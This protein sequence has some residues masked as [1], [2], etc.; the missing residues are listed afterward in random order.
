MN[1]PLTS[2]RAIPQRNKSP[3]DKNL[4]T[5][6]FR[7]PSPSDSEDDLEDYH[8]PSPRNA[9]ET[10]LQILSSG[11]APRAENEDVV[12]VSQSQVPKAKNMIRKDHVDV[13]GLDTPEPAA[14]Q[15]KA[16]DTVS[17]PANMVTAAT[18]GHDSEEPEVE[19]IIKQPL[20]S[21]RSIVIDDEEYEQRGSKDRENDM[22]KSSV[23]DNIDLIEELLTYQP[24]ER[25]ASK[26]KEPDTIRDRNQGPFAIP[27]P[28]PDMSVE[29]E[30]SP[31]SD[32]HEDIAQ[33][34]IDE[35]TDDEIDYNS[36]SLS[37]HSNSLFDEQKNEL[38]EDDI[39]DRNG[40]ISF[41]L[42]PK[43]EEPRKRR[44][45]ISLYGYDSSDDSDFPPSADKD[46]DADSLIE[47][48]EYSSVRAVGDQSEEESEYEAEDDL[49]EADL[50]EPI[51]EPRAPVMPHATLS[52]PITAGARAPSP[53]D[54]A[55]AKSSRPIVPA[56]SGRRE[57]YLPPRDEHIEYAAP[58]D[59][60][61]ARAA[62]TFPEPSYY[63]P[64]TPPTPYP[65]FANSAAYS[66][67]YDPM[68]QYHPNVPMPF[69]FANQQP[70]T[71]Y[72][73]SRCYA[74]QRATTADYDTS[75][76]V[77]ADDHVTQ[78]PKA[79]AK[80]AKV[81]ISDIVNSSPALSR[82][83]LSE[84]KSGK[85][86]KH[87]DIGSNGSAPPASSAFSSRSFPVDSL[88]AGTLGLK[89]KA[90]ELDD[91]LQSVLTGS[92]SGIQQ[93]SINVENTQ[94]PGVTDAQPRETIMHSSGI[95]ED[96]FPAP[97]TPPKESSPVVD[98]QLLAALRKQ[99]QSLSSKTSPVTDRSNA[100]RGEPAP[101]KIK[102]SN[103]PPKNERK[104]KAK[105]KQALKTFVSGCIAGAFTVVGAAAALI[106]TM[107]ASV[108]EEA[109]RSI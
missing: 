63:Q 34:E 29:R 32:I 71:V 93:S 95:I 66:S 65:A 37:T 99:A 18:S 45:K 83:G 69:D 64:L 44:E 25:G 48:S 100:D 30:L 3:R 108:Q 96:S 33:A 52:A 56:T 91:V 84:R 82:K 76:P 14:T 86:A 2:Y 101:K 72:P 70:P 107:P 87:K 73:L 97:M 36:D 15:S 42:S 28:R 20:Q 88:A 1:S 85:E 62:P 23:P 31:A 106:A 4:P 58:L 68:P 94:T 16:A 9:R 38:S 53:S 92:S 105:G 98:Q 26:A 47:V 12:F 77:Q 90:A 55:M 103:A 81:H 13:I 104:P 17:K 22:F 80:S 7:V 11:F 41:P 78:V 61:P 6:V 10:S 74:N 54:A 51:S 59:G 19:M 5:N 50:H 24:E 21:S 27:V 109:L 43:N 89:R 75:A 60:F 46:D 8:P 39:E 79:A 49:F 57:Q 35:T 40:P 102:T 67:F